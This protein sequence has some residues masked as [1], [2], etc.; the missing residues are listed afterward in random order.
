MLNNAFFLFIIT[1]NSGSS[2]RKI[3]TTMNKNNSG[4]FNIHNLNNSSI[5]K[6]S[7]MFMSAINFAKSVE[8][9]SKSGSLSS[10][11][12]GTLNELILNKYFSFKFEFL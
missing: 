6:N 12:L 1:N 4:D 5:S 10:N 3:R 11:I 8:K 9:A 2:R 7:N